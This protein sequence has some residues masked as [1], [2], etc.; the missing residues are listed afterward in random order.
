MGGGGSNRVQIGS[1]GKSIAII[2][3]RWQYN[4]L[5]LIVRGEIYHSIFR[6]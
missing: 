4:E 2:K 1:K 5:K 6:R 3:F